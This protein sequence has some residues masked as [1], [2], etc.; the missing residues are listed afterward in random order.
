MAKKKAGRAALALTG[1]TLALVLATGAQAHEGQDAQA[2]HTHKVTE[3][4]AAAQKPAQ[5]SLRGAGGA[6]IARDESTGVLRAP[7]DAEAAALAGPAPSSEAMTTR[8]PA[9]SLTG[10]AVMVPEELHA[11]A[12][13]TKRADGTLDQSCVPSKEAVMQ[14]LAAMRKPAQR[15]PFAAPSLRPAEGAP[16]E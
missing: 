9:A 10:T 15:A 1:S 2:G 11:H 5:R 8:I 4:K 13:V 6:S 12:I 3:Q 16:H 14:T 7:T